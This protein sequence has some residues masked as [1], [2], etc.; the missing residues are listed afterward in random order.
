[1]GKNG[2]GKSTIFKALTNVIRPTSGD[3]LLNNK[4]VQSDFSTV[5]QD[6]GYC[7]QEDALFPGLTIKEHLEFYCQICGATQS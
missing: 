7:P 4:S 2:A 1:L 6:L 5:R 3:V